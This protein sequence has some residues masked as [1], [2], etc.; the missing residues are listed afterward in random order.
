MRCQ[1]PWPPKQSIGTGG[2]EE[3]NGKSEERGHG[4]LMKIADAQFSYCSHHYLLADWCLLL[5]K[6]AFL[7]LLVIR[8]QAP[9][10]LSLCLCL[11][12]A[13]Q[14][15]ASRDAIGSQR[16]ASAALHACD[17]QTKRFLSLLQVASRVAMMLPLYVRTSAVPCSIVHLNEWDTL[18]KVLDEIYPLYRWINSG[19]FRVSSAP[20][21]INDQKSNDINFV[22]K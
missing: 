20:G 12:L 14:K 7:L 10:S 6:S 1:Q 15:L 5:S 4:R 11:S 9:C 22:K 21:T 17:V 16:T 18:L 8:Q 3:E 2:D 19:K 13:S